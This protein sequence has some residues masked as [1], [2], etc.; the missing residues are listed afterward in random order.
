MEKIISSP[1]KYIQGKGVLSSL[2]KYSQQLGK[3]AIIL[4]GGT[5]QEIVAPLISASFEA[6]DAPF[7]METFNGECSRAEID[8]LLA[9]CKAQQINVVIG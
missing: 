3:K 4:S 6:A 9:I 5:V 2:A 7:H 8:R 1:G